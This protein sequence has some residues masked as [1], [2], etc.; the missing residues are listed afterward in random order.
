MKIRKDHWLHSGA[1]LLI[2]LLG[3]YLF[4]LMLHWPWNLVLAGVL[5]LGIGIGKE[6][7]DAMSEG[8]T[9]DLTDLVA[10]LVGI[11]VAVGV[12]FLLRAI[13]GEK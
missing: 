6:F 10:D 11:A 2:T 5:A 9:F 12:T 3:F 7:G 4:G 1:C 8:N 13:A